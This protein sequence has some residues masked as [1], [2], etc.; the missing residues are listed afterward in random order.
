[1]NLQFFRALIPNLFSSLFLVKR[2]KNR[3]SVGGEGDGA[4][5]GAEIP[6]GSRDPPH[7]PRVTWACCPHV[8]G[9][10][11][12]CGPI[13]LNHSV[14]MSLGLGVPLSQMLIFPLLPVLMCVPVSP[15]PVCDGV[16]DDTGTGTVDAAWGSS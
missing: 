14:L 12:P 1:M 2:D 16:A 11:G 3:D 10:G 5:A 15:V 4:N 8:P 6:Q 13:S 9:S 7:V